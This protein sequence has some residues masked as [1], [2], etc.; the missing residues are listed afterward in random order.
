MRSGAHAK[1]RRLAHIVQQRAPGQRRRAARLQLLQQQQR[2]NPDIALGM[3][4]RRLLHALHPRDFR[5][6]LG[7]QPGLIEQFKG[8]PRMALGQHLGQLVAHPL[9]AHRVNA[10]GE[11]HGSPRRSAPP[12]ANPKRA[13][14]R[15]AAQQA[16]LVFFKA[17]PRLADG[18]NHPG[19]EVRQAAD[20]IQHRRFADV[21]PRLSRVVRI[22]RAPAASGSSSSPLIVKSRR[23]TS[24]SAIWRVAHRVGMPPVGIRP[25]RPERR[26]LGR[27]SVAASPPPFRRVAES[28]PPQVATSTTPKC[29]PTANVRGN[30]L[31]HHVGRRRSR[32]VVVHRLP[33]QQQIAHAP[34]GEIG[35]IPAPRAASPQSA[36]PLRI[37]R[38][39]EPSCIPFSPA[40]AGRLHSTAAG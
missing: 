38:G 9:P 2:V 35:L 8:P 37:G 4:L 13:A 21:P 15:T 27:H 28:A 32:H 5:Q 10:R 6:H 3:K 17:P 7:Q 23:C 11:R 14:K 40:D 31:Q 16:Q 12:A 25:I 34:A 33:T 36:A 30:M 26:H 29:A 39:P 18:A 1:R 22:A 20:V 19:I 24:S